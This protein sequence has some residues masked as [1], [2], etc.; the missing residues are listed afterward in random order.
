MPVVGYGRKK[1]ENVTLT[2]IRNI[3]QPTSI[4]LA[5]TERIP[6][7]NFLVS[8]IAI[9]PSE[10]GRGVPYTSLADDLS[11][12]DLQNPVQAKL[13]SVLRIGLDVMAA[14]AYK[15]TK[16]KYAVTGVATNNIATNGTFG[17]TSTDNMNY[18]HMEQIRD[19]LFDTLGA[20]PAVG[21][22]Y[23][24]IFRTLALRGIKDDP[25]FDEWHKY[26]DPQSK[27]NSEV[28]KI[29]SIR[30][31]ETNNS[32]SLGKVGTGS[33][34]GEGVV[35]GADAVAMAEIRSPELMATSGD[36][37]NA[38]RDKMV[39]FYGNIDFGIIWDTAN[40]G[41]GKIIHVGSL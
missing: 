34:L 16:I 20:P 8:T 36:P 13:E 33:V 35:F 11:F 10:I 30:L 22:D 31:K 15:S 7:D 12:F 19:Y 14:I 29:E 17:A 3:T 24:G 27:A 39:L 18:F 25:A 37:A 28:G 5:E 4:K 21:E 26:T 40:F 38:G 2:R 6:E 23:I 1:G 41:E 9:T 32:S